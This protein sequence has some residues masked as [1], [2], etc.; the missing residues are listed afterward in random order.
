FGHPRSAFSQLFRRFNALVQQVNER[1]QL[2]QRLA[3]EERLAAVGRLASGLAHEI[4]NPLGGM[5]TALDTLQKHGDRPEVRREG[6]ALLMRGLSGIRDVVRSTLAAYKSGEGR[7]DLQPADLDD[8]R[9]LIQHEVSR[10]QL[11]L[12]W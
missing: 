1:E 4:N 12:D 7:R 8:L 5:Q 2:L 6:V 3:E 11:V 9:Y 10:R